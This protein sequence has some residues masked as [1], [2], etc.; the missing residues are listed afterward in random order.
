ML[1]NIL[2]FQIL[3]ISGGGWF[4]ILVVLAL[5]V[6]MIFTKIRTDIVFLGAMTLLFVSGVVDAKGAFGGLSSESVLV[7]A[8]LYIVIEGL[9]YTGVLNWMVKHLMGSPQS[10]AGAI[11]RIVLPVAVLSSVL[12]NTTVVALFINIVKI[13]SKKLGIAPSKLLIPLSYAAGMGGICTLIGTPPNLIISGLYTE[14]TGIALNIFTTTACGLFCLA[15]GLLSLIVMQ[16]LLPTRNSPLTA[17]SD[18]DFTIELK[19]PSDHPFIGMTL[20]EIY[21]QNPQG[22][23]NTKGSILAIRRFDN[24][25]EVASPD[26]F[27]MGADHIIVSGKAKELQWLCKNLNLQNEHLKGVLENEV[28]DSAIGR[29][30]I[31]SSA[32]MVAMILLSAFKVMPL[33]SCCLLAAAAMII[34]KCCTSDQAMKSINWEIVMIFAGSFCVGKALGDTGVAEMVAQGLLNVCGTNPYIVLIVMCLVATFITEFIS[35]TAA[36]AMFFPIAMSAATTLE[37]NPLTFCIALMI[38]AS[39]SFATPIGSATHML[40]YSPGGYKFTDFVKIGLPMN[41]IILAANVFI[42]TIMFPLR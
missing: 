37:V 25:V 7:V 35:N 40:V 15:V 13:W 27:I 1:Q 17:A 6:A 28:D 18:E 32:I 23:E 31:V 2:D 30:T 19:V 33:L 34:C 21:D 24:E 10:L 4:T 22:F 38:A 3:G 20:Q 9:T 5:F 41:F 29:K 26:S 39:S 11:T 14:R 36:A 16:K 12:T 42:T 8:V